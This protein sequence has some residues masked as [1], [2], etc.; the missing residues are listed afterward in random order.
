MT[1]ERV[2]VVSRSELFNGSNPHGFLAGD[3]PHT[4]RFLEAIRRGGW[5]APRRE[6]EGRPD[7]KQII[8]YVVVRHQGSVLLLERLSG[9]T[10]RRLEGKLS[11][12]VGGHVN[13]EDAEGRTLPRPLAALAD[14]L[15]SMVTAAAW[16]ELQEEVELAGIA[17]MEL[18]GFV[19]DDTNSVGSVHFGLVLLAE[20]SAPHVR[21][22]EEGELSG[23]F[24][25]ADRLWSEGVWPRLETWSQLVA[26]GLRHVGRL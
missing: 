26:D 23:R 5:F 18:A 15:G 16:R 8:P 14:R 4:S 3:G 24:V 7:W 12:G 13:P 25:P 10:E 19:N 17:R 11:L 22:L 2:Y 9:V 6:A 20:A 21:V 1:D